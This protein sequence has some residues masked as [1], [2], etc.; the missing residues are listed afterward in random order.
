ME[1]RK[2]KEVAEM[3]QEVVSIDEHSTKWKTEELGEK[4]KT[5]G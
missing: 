5:N 3:L 1:M 2:I 4:M